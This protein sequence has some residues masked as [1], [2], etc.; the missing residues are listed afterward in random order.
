MR[1]GVDS[2][3]RPLLAH[4]YDEMAIALS[5]HGR[6]LAYQSNETG[7]IE[8]FVR[9]FPDVGSGKVQVSSAGGTAPLW[10]RDGRTFYYLRGGD[11]VTA[12]PVTVDGTLGLAQTPALFTLPPGTARLGARYYTPWDIA[13]DGRFIMVESV[14]ATASRGNTLQVVENGLQEVKAMLEDGGHG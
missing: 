1:L 9:P 4:P 3:P 14:D 10:A 5:P 13:P 2:V 11:A 12:V 7:R 8:V 6:W